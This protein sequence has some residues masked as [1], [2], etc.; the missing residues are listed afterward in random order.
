MK[1]RWDKKYLYWG[2]TAFLV[3]LFSTLFFFAILR[4][5]QVSSGIK[6]IINI[7]KPVLYGLVIA[8]LLTPVMNFFET[9]ILR[10][11]HRLNK[12]SKKTVKPGKLKK[13]A[14]C[15]SIF[16]TLIL[17]LLLLTALISMIIP[18]LIQSITGFANGFPTYVDQFSAWMGTHLENNSQFKAFAEQTFEKLSQNYEQWWQNLKPALNSVVTGVTTGV[19]GIFSALKNIL[20]GFIISIYVMFSKDLFAAQGKKLIYAIFEL[21]RANAFLSTARQTHRIFSGFIV[22]KLLDSLIIGIICFIC[23]SIFNWPFALLISV[24]IGVTNI[25]PFFGPFIG[26]IPTAFIILLIEPMTCIY[27]IIFILILQQFDGN[28]LG[29]KILGDSTGLSSFW[30]IFAILVAGGLFGFIGMIIG[31][32]LFAV[33]YSMLKVITTKSL[34]EKGLPSKTEDY[35]NLI[36]ID[37]K[38]KKVIEQ[39]ES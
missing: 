31:V 17:M 8:Y 39:K 12:A 16:I 10:L 23:M 26:A 9:R 3:I 2:L 29:P 35:E 32:P 11:F 36:Y 4:I 19:V 38:D 20:I 1:Y 22:G 5:D 14:R 13:I 37:A 24:I 27:F 28:I 18:Q 34:A 15:I 25:I 30:V 33:I 6:T 21:K 7:L